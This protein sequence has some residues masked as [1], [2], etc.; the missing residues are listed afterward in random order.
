MARINTE[1][2]D[3]ALTDGEP[4][5][6]GIIKQ[7]EHLGLRGIPLRHWRLNPVYTW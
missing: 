6:F 3:G 5:A 7:S 2:T 1:P 4:S